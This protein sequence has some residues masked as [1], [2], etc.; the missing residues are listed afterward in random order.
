MGLTSTDTRVDGFF[1][2]KRKFFG[3]CDL[4]RTNAKLRVRDE[5]DHA[6]L[7]QKPCKFVIQKK[8]FGDLIIAGAAPPSIFV[9]DTLLN[10]FR[11]AKI[12]GYEVVAADARIPFPHNP[13]RTKFWQ[14][15]VT[16]WGGSASPLSGIAEIDRNRFGNHKYTPCTNVKM[17]LDPGQHDGSDLFLVWP[18]PTKVWVSSKLKTLLHTNGI[19]HFD[20]SPVESH[21]FE[22]LDEDPIGFGPKPLACYLPPDRA[23]EVGSKSGIDWFEH[24]KAPFPKS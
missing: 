9:S 11:D 13:E 1:F 4:D 16:G 3:G 7:F 12:T 23:T 20:L 21:R 22:R 15:V 17:I 10:I 5:L 8:A 2:L 18:L 24:T 6:F 19:K 14:L